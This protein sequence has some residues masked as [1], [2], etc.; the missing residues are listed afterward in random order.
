VFGKYAGRV[1]R[2]ADESNE[3]WGKSIEDVAAMAAGVGDILKP[4]G[5]T[6]KQATKLTLSVGDLIPAL[7]EW[8]TVGMDAEQVSYA[9]TAAMTGEREMLKS[10]GIVIMEEDVKAKVKAMEAAGQVHRRKPTSRSK[11]I[12]TLKLAT[13]GSAD[14]MKSYAGQ[15]RQCRPGVEPCTCSRGRSA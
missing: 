9:L 3:L 6:T 12:A 4:L 5:F 11:A 2:W 1:R 15:Q 14:A 10:L 8:N 13:E 7:A